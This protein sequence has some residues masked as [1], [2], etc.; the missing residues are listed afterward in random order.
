LYDPTEYLDRLQE[1]V[2]DTYITVEKILQPGEDLPQ[3]WHIQGTSGYDYLNYVNTIFCQTNN[4]KKFDQ[5]YWNFTGRR[6]PF[7]E[8]TA[9]KK[10]LIL[11]KSLAGDIDNLATIL[12]QL[13]SRYRYGND[14]TLNGLKRAIAEVLIRFPI[15]RTYTNAAGVLETDRP[16]IE[17][18]I[19]IA[20]D[21][22]PLLQNELNFIEKLL[23]LEYDTSL[24][25][26][27]KE[28]WL[29]LV[30]RLQQYTGPLM[31][32][33]VEDTALYVYN[34]LLSLNEVGGDP[35]HFG[36]SLT[37]F[38][39]FNQT[40]QARWLHTMNTTSTHDTKRGE[41]VRAR[42]NVLSEIPDEWQ[43][44]V[45]AWSELNAVYK[46]ETKNGVFPD[47]ND[48]YALYQTLIGAYP[49]A[50]AELDSFTSRIKDFVLKAIREAKLFTTWLRNNPVYEDACL[51]FVEA[52]LNPSNPFLQQFLPFQQRI[53]HY[54]VLNSLSQTLLKITSPGVP[55]FYQ[56]TE[57][58][59]LNLVDP[60]NR[61][62]IDFEQ[63]RIWLH[64]IKQRQQNLPDLISEL[65]THPQ[66]GRLKLFLIVQALKARAD[67]KSVF[68]DGS[69]QPL[70]VS[71]SHQ[72]HLVAFARIHQSGTLITIAPRFLIDLV[73]PGQYP[74]GEQIWEE[75]YVH[76]PA[77]FASLNNVITGQSIS[78]DHKLAVGEALQHFP[79]A[80]LAYC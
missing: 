75:T 15:Y 69:Y 7:S 14:F 8:L 9:E 17:E 1:K 5:I 49:F 21:H 60:D 51:K 61:R 25:T 66:D 59:D 63:R 24:S 65:L 74:L 45:Q 42:I 37:D 3:V 57:L 43:Q 36:L 44:Q 26:T 77:E 20:K 62:P 35:E 70:E 71:G 52:V 67:Y 13:S 27:D 22:A 68:L 33:G 34:R 56:G 28:Q 76:L 58:W 54:G 19:Q 6:T 12:K 39:Q 47:P 23:L 2:G 72:N 64:E 79:V 55:D 53:A 32:K 38:H 46:T 48:E 16:Y 18:V 40:R 29:Y 31:A 4:Q 41:D 10:Y 50:E 80:L 78:T 30:M 73:Q 11:D